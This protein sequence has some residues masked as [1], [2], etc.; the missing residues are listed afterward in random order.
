M[1]MLNCARM[2]AASLSPALQGH[3]PRLRMLRG[4]A[5]LLHMPPLVQKQQQ[6]QLAFFLPGGPTGRACM[7]PEATYPLSP[8]RLF[9]TTMRAL[10]AAA[11]K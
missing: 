2:A 8:H 6:Q 1:T 4:F 11:L 3:Q 9:P 5:G 7:R 10:P